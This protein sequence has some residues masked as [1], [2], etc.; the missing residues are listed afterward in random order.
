MNRR[1]R[2]LL[3]LLLLCL[4]LTLA[5]VFSHG[6]AGDAGNVQEHEALLT[7]WKDSVAD[8]VRQHRYREAVPTLRNYLRHAPGDS[9][10]RRLLGKV[11]F[12]TRR[13]PEARDVYYV[14]LLHDPDD[15]VARSNLGVVLAKQGKL[16]EALRELR[17][18]FV[19]S[20]REVFIGANLA[21]GYEL[22]GDS[23][24]A[25]EVWRVLSGMVQGGEVRIPED[26]LMLDNAAAGI[27][28]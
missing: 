14:V 26:A 25:G 27:K 20:G 10:M 6:V 7:E 13:Y 2:M 21:R 1:G 19:G 12:E 8:M 15:F 18:A 9:A 22:A 17:E 3:I 24:A 23:L 4:F 28:P 16:Q 5:V 11:L